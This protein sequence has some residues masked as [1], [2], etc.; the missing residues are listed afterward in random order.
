MAKHENLSK[1]I[2]FKKTLPYV[3]KQKKLFIISIIL[4]LVVAVLSAVTP[5]ITKSIIDEFLPKSEFDNIFKA[6]I[7]Y[8]VITC[9]SVFARYFYQYLHTLNLNASEKSL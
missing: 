4:S 3:F 7:I 6:L 9:M 8:A 1:S 5:F 2:I